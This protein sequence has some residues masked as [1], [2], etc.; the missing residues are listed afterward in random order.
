[1]QNLQK[2]LKKNLKKKKVYKMD[3]VTKIKNT[4]TSTLKTTLNKFGINDEVIRNVQDNV[5]SAIRTPVERV[6]DTVRRVAG[7]YQKVRD[8]KSE[9]QHRNNMGRII[10]E[11]P[12]EFLRR[13]DIR[14]NRHIEMSRVNIIPRDYYEIVRIVSDR[15]TYSEV[16]GIGRWDY[17]ILFDSDK[18]RNDVNNFEDLRTIVVDSIDHLVKTVIKEQRLQPDQTVR[19]RPDN[20]VNNMNHEWRAAAWMPNNTIAAEEWCNINEGFLQSWYLDD[21]DDDFYLTVTTFRPPGGRGRNKPSIMEDKK[22]S[23]YRVRNIDSLCG[24]RA[25][26]V[27]IVNKQRK[28]CDPINIEEKQK[29]NNKYRSYTRSDT[30]NL[31]QTKH[32]EELYDMIGK[33]HNTRTELED[34]KA[35]ELLLNAKIKTIKESCTTPKIFNYSGNDEIKDDKPIYYLLESDD[36]YDAITSITGYLGVSYFCDKCEKGFN[37]KNNHLC[38]GEVKCKLCQTKGVD[39][40]IKMLQERCNQCVGGNKCVICRLSEWLKCDVCNVSY[41]QGEC[42]QNHLDKN[43]CTKKVKCES[44]NIILRT[45]IDIERHKCG[46]IE[47]ESCGEYDVESHQC[48]MKP[49]VVDTEKVKEKLNLYYYFDFESRQEDLSKNGLLKHVVNYGILQD[50]CGNITEIDDGD[51]TLES[52]CKEIFQKKNSGYTFIAHNLKG[53][54]GQFILKWALD[55]GL[56]PTVIYAGSKI[57]Y[58]CI[59]KYELKFIDSVNFLQKPL[60]DLPKM[61][62][63]DNIKKGYFPHKFNTLKNQNYVGKYPDVSFY[64]PNKMKVKDRESFFKWYNGVKND[65]F[66]FKK[67]MREYCIDDVNILR[68]A[69]QAFQESFMNITDGQVDPFQKITIASACMDTFKIMDLDDKKI[70]IINN[71]RYMKEKESLKA[72]MCLEYLSFKD[73]C[74]IQHAGNGPQKRIKVKSGKVYKVDGYIE[75]TDTVY[76]FDGCYWHGC[77]KC[78]PNHK[79]NRV[80]K[81]TMLELRKATEI[82]QREIKECVKELVVIKECEWDQ[83]INKYTCECSTE[84]C[85]DLCEENKKKIQEYKKWERT[86]DKSKIVGKLMPRKAFFGG[87]TEGHRLYHKC[88]QNEKILYLDYTSLYPTI[89]KYGWYPIGH[90]KLHKDITPEDAITK[91]GLIYCDILPPRGLYYPVLPAK[92]NGK[93]NF[94]LCITCGETSCNDKC[95]HNDNERMLRGTWTHLEILKAIEKGYRINKVHSMEVFEQGETGLFKDYVNRFLKIKQESSGWPKDCKSDEQKEEY[96]KTYYEREGVLLEKSKIEH[97]AGMREVS[98]LFLNSLWGKFGQ[99]DNMTKTKFIREPSE[100]YSMKYST[101]YEIMDEM[102][103]NDE[104]KGEDPL[105]S[106]KYRHKDS[107]LPTQNNVNVFIAI[108]TTSQA[109]LKLYDVLDKYNEKV[110]YCD[111]DSV[112][113]LMDKDTKLDLQIGDYLGWL[114]D[115]LGGDYITEFCTGGPKNYGYKTSDGKTKCVVKGFSLNYEN[116]EKINLQTMID[117][118]KREKQNYDKSLEEQNSIVLDNQFGIVR[119]G[120]VV[121]TEYSS[122]KYSFVFDKR[123]IDWKTYNTYPYGY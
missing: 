105:I 65:V 89:N 51:N 70:A 111:T 95:N 118:V 45:K 106:I 36:H 90:P 27:C 4:I 88:K 103:I 21:F 46:Y 37:D 24:A 15:P 119:R 42:F 80:N 99:R 25:L 34:I 113:I 23:I 2:N 92:V 110:L 66:D 61:F 13:S 32:A 67:E 60:S 3:W 107:E 6:R 76:E 73:K 104:S 74:H 41:I 47:C 56:T 53:Y 18:L 81:K 8:R 68:R 114:K 77:E 112:F 100:Y 123:V 30:S 93:L 11:I 38:E 87:R 22:K 75:S 78:Y 50:Y 39:H 85:S 7:T 43:M 101:Q 72:I 55:N 52:M 108:Y 62:N 69:C 57:M 116:S 79:I 82:R 5:R 122:K 9:I 29:L 84:K 97:N 120:G 54:D 20:N 83:K 63:F 44:C 109:R 40:K 121:Y 35:W 115:E 58:M 17:T 59:E 19:I 26:A 1:L 49:K 48:Y 12:T 98:K 31:P 16:F 96:I 94:I 117:M 64:E 28:D 10:E 14:S 71:S 91:K 86:F 102:I 33:K